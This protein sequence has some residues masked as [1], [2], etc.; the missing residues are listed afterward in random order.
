MCRKKTNRLYREEKLTVPKRAGRKWA[1]GT[2]AP[3]AVPQEANQLSFSTIAL[4]SLAAQVKLGFC[5]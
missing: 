4:Q 1:M 3:I 2:Q 5:V